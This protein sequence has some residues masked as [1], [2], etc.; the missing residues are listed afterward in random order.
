MFAFARDLLPVTSSAIPIGPSV[1]A[2][3]VGLAVLFGFSLPPLLRLRDVPPVRIFQRAAGNRVRRFDVLYLIPFAVSALLIYLE[4]D[5]P[6]LAND[7]QCESVRRRHRCAAGRRGVDAH[8]PRSAHGMA[9]AL[10]FGLANLA[11]RRALS[12]LQIVALA[13]AITALDL[14]AIVGPSLLSA[15][16]AELPANTPNYFLINIQPEQRDAVIA[17]TPIRRSGKYQRAAACGKQ[18]RRDQ[19]RTA[20]RGRLPR[21]PRRRMDQR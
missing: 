20:A 5:T 18:T 2:F 19:R 3:A 1:A 14:L 6:K 11:R 12:L 21:S 17:Q 8:C 16:R 4:S 13:L 15:W 7:S 10:R 9:G